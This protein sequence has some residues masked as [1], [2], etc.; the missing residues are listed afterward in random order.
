MIQNTHARG[1][2]KERYD[3]ARQSV[4]ESLGLR[5]VMEVPRILKVVINIGL[6]EAVSNSK[7]LGTGTHV[8]EAI[9]GQ[10]VLRTTA[11]KSVASFK[12]REGMPIG[13]CVTL[14]GTRMHVFLDKLINLAL[15]KVRDFQGVPTRLDG[16]GNYNL[17][18]K[19]WT[20]FPEAEGAGANES[21]CGMNVT[22]VTSTDK[23]A[24]AFALLKAMNM[25]FRRK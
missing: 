4:K 19:E 6:K 10:K 7:I 18:I 22:I 14:R 8:L 1:T 20:I 16:Q 17:G 25:P 13:L 23:D 5:N 9:A 24:H 2:S 21:S 11:R 3:Q 12:I 15:P